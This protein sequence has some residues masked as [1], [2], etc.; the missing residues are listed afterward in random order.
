MR[1]VV[2]HDPSGVL[3][4]I[5]SPIRNLFSPERSS[6]RASDVGSAGQASATEEASAEAAS[7]RARAAA[8][9]QT[10]R[11]TTLLTGGATAAREIQSAR[12]T[13]LGSTT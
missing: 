3:K 11:R 10:G 13:L 4:S 2:L 5:T 9:A 6:F 8:A 12:R 1:H 7:R